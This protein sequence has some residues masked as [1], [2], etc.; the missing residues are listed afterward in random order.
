MRP[1]LGST[2]MVAPEL[3]INSIA[4]T[5]S[6]QRTRRTTTHFFF[7]ALHLL[8]GAPSP[9][10]GRLLLSRRNVIVPLIFVAEETFPEKRAVEPCTV[11]L[12]VTSFALMV[13]VTS[14]GPCRPW[15]VP[16]IFSPSC[17]RTYVAR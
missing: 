17:F 16:V 7:S 4:S 1:N 2:C 10:G 15:Y 12:S 5:S 6:T 11:T 13:P 8:V 14:A 3:P 9:A